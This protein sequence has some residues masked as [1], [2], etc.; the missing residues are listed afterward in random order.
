MVAD[1]PPAGRGFGEARVKGR[2]RERPV[3]KAWEFV[4]KA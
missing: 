4:T 1:Q 3:T 2:R